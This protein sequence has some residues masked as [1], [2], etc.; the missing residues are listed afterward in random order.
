MH[1]GPPKWLGGTPHA[2]GKWLRAR[3]HPRS[4]LAACGTTSGGGATGANCPDTS[5][6]HLV[7]A[8]T[9]TIASDTTYK[10]AEFVDR[11]TQ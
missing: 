4:G 5:N 3:G 1:D 8:G 6:L 11:T 9:L 2:L 7:Q 10:P